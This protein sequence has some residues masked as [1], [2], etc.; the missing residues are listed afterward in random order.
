M[1]GVRQRSAK[2]DE[3]RQNLSERCTQ[4][5]FI[6]M[7]D[8]VIP[9][10]LLER[11]WSQEASSL[12]TVW[13]SK[14]QENAGNMHPQ[15]CWRCFGVFR[16]GI[17]VFSDLM[18]TF[19]ASRLGCY[20]HVLW[21][22]VE[23]ARIRFRDLS[24]RWLFAFFIENEPTC[25]RSLLCETDTRLKIFV[26]ARM[27][28]CCF[29]GSV[30]RVRTCSKLHV[31]RRKTAPCR[32]YSYAHVLHGRKNGSAQRILSV[33]FIHACIVKSG[34]LRAEA[35]FS[36]FI[37]IHV[38]LIPNQERLCAEAWFILYSCMHVWWSQHG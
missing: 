28:K 31:Y 10:F 9:C 18:V 26:H 17:S 19:E 12:W 14:V 7:F 13:V 15:S 33:L 27:L 4:K 21:T 5:V 25:S 24:T 20:E 30:H 6:T 32:A 1:L 36:V 35:E 34:W 37:H 8:I 29:L 11:M 16:F 22:D 3:R 2:S 38:H 23:T